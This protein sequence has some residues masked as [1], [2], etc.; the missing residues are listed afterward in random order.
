MPAVRHYSKLFPDRKLPV[1]SIHT[2]KTRYIQELGKRKQEKSDEVF[3][4]KEPPNKKRGQP[5][6][7]GKEL[8]HQVELFLNHLHS[9]GAVINTAI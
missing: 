1:S 7:L 8:D 3:N 5:L 6:M 9:T 4:I 2:W